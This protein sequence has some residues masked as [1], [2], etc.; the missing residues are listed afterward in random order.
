MKRIFA[1]LLLATPAAAEPH[2][3]LGSLPVE[4]IGDWGDQALYV[5][6]EEMIR[7]FSVNV[8]G[9][10]DVAGTPVLV[11]YVSSGGNACGEV[12]FVVALKGG[13]PTL[14]GPIDSC[15]STLWDEAEGGYL[16]STPAMP[17]Q[18]G[19]AWL[20][21]PEGG[22]VSAPPID[23]QPDPTMTW[24][25]LAELSPTHPFD[26]LYFPEIDA[27][28]QRMTGGDHAVLYERIA[29]LGSGEMRG[30]DFF[31][32]SCIKWT[33]DD[34]RMMLFADGSDRRLF[35]A[36]TVGGESAPHMVPDEGSWTRDAYAAFE[37][38]GGN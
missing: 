8:E 32:A 23:Y 35:L 22:L 36:W 2:G 1:V 28:I 14:Y 26:L 31:G 27:E 13:V 19:D 24:D 5:N 16:F 33:C 3:S 38:W 37:E 10:E 29:G 18:P 30:E 15:A 20:W 9:I 4:V 12:N 7:D 25:R 11:G 34:D 6:G 21:T 17:G